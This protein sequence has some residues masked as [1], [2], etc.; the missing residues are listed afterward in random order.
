M[1]VA[2]PKKELVESLTRMNGVADPKAHH[3]P[4][5]MVVVAV[6]GPSTVRLG[7][8][9]GVV[10]LACTLTADVSDKGAIAAPCKDVLERVKAM[11]DGVVSI[12]TKG[13]SIILR[14]AASSRRY[15]LS[16]MS[17]DDVRSGEG[18]DNLPWHALTAATWRT[19][20]RQTRYAMSDDETR[21]HLHATL[22]EWQGARI[23][24]VATDGHRLAIAD[25]DT[26]GAQG[27]FVTLL[28]KVTVERMHAIVGALGSDDAVQ[29]AST[30]QMFL[31]R[32]GNYTLTSR[33]TD[34]KFPPYEQVVPKPSEA[35]TVPRSMLLDAVRAVLVAAHE[36]TKGIK[37][38][39]EANLV[40]VESQTPEGDGADDVTCDYDG[41]KATIGLSGEYLRDCLESV[42]NDVVRIG[43]MA[44]NPLSPILVS[45]NEGASFQF[46]IMPMRT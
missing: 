22:L 11:P 8:D 46:V 23:R 12:E 16:G 38:T 10:S 33:I 37:L 21:A 19:L 43:F 35:L 6:D 15:S 44:S 36:K 39:V 28:P 7:A 18:D 32:A 5:R 40:H 14:S 45:P 2:I 34:G 3:A 1:K 42:E 13:T 24:F 27:S 26:G 17:A 30:S 20:T 9:N 31:A 25:A 4:F 41:E 29:V